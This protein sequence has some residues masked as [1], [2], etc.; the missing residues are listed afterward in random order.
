MLMLV[1]KSCSGKTTIVKELKKL[2]LKE[3]I[4]YTTRPKREHETEGVEYHFITK[5][6]FLQKEEQG[7]FAETSSYNVA[8]GEQ[9]YY[10]SAIEDL[11]NDKVFIVN[12]QVLKKMKNIDT[13]IPISF[14]ITA[15]DE[16]IWE[17]LKQRK[18]NVNEAIRRL[19]ADRED[20]RD[21]YNYVDFVFSNDLG[22]KPELLAEMIL[23]TY[24][25]VM[26]NDA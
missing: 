13:L 9:W 2:G 18:D 1:G 23:Y 3:V 14:Y 6:E 19:N 26:G 16:T 4:S 24:K 20:F 21:I 8:T 7:F 10:G 17:R 11:T 25:K 5:E 12:P 22:L 15:S